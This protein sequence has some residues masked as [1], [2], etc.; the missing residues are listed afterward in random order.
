MNMQ[1]MVQQMQKMQRQY[2]KD[3]KIIEETSFSYTANGAVKLTLKGDMSFESI[4]FLDKDIL[5]KEN[6]EMISDMIKVA[7]ENV[8]KQ[9]LDEEDKLA[10]KYKSLGSLGF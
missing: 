5:D 8:R 9:V 10:E 2:E 3:H 7:Y 6:E 1:Q 4:E